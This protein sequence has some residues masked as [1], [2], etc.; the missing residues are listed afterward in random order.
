MKLVTFASPQKGAAYYRQHQ[1]LKYLYQQGME[2]VLLPPPVLWDNDDIINECIKHI[3]NADIFFVWCPPV[4]LYKFFQDWKSIKQ[5]ENKKLKFVFDYDDDLWNVH[6]LNPAYAYLGTQDVKVGDEYVFKSGV[7]VI[8]HTATGMVSRP[9]D[10]VK[11]S[12]NLIKVRQMITLADKII[13]PSR[14]LMGKLGVYRGKKDIIGDVIYIPNGID[15]RIF[16]RSHKERLDDKVNIVWTL[17]DSHFPD[18]AHVRGVIGKVLREN[19]QAHLYMFGGQFGVGRDIPLS[20]LTR[21]G[22]N[23]DMAKY[24]EALSDIQPDIGLC[25]VNDNEFNRGKSILKWGEYTAV[26]ATSCGSRVLYGDY[27]SDKECLLADNKEEFGMNLDRLINNK[28]L[29]QNVLNNADNMYREQ[30]ILP[31]I[32]EKYKNVFNNLFKEGLQ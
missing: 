2:I 19:P 13:T 6:P 23:G 24:A 4:D 30:Y 10:P 32:A 5:T 12:E 31:V 27:L 21:I 11:N 14:Y 15:N 25:W 20:Q 17:S 3:D 16:K 26:G 22:F 18:F 1:I 7:D 29:R 8:I 9:F 28:E